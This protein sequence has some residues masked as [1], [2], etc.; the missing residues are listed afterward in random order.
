MGDGVTLCLG[1]CLCRSD[2]R[3]YDHD[4]EVVV[5]SIVLQ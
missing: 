3:C 5:C 2:E 4:G 1:L